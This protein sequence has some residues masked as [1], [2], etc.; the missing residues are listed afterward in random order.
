M[1]ENKIEIHYW[2]SLSYATFGVA[3]ENGIVTIAPPIGKWMIGKNIDFIQKWV[4]KKHGIFKKL[5]EESH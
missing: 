3:T 4:E 1:K 5:E 2:I